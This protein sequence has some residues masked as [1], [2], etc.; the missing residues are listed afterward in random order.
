MATALKTL[1]SLA[2]ATAPRPNRIRHPR[3]ATTTS[4]ESVFNGFLYEPL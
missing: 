1:S 3:L 4:I 2:C